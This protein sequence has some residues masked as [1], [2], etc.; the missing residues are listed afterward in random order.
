MRRYIVFVLFFSSSFLF[1]QKVLSLDESIKTAL[2]KSYAIKSAE[3]SLISSRKNLES[4]KSGLMTSV[5]MEFDIPRYSRSLKSQFNPET[6]SEQFFQIGST[7]LESRLFFTQPIP[8]TNGSFSLVGSIFG[9]EQ[10]SES[11]GTFRDYYSNLSLRFR[12]PIFAFNSL[13]ASLERAGINL[14]RAE[15]NYNRAAQDIIYSVKQ[16][17]FQLFKAKKNVEIVEEKVNQTSLSYDKALNK[18][19]AG[20]IAEVE[21]LQL[22][23]DMTAS[24]NELLN[25]QVQL[26]EAKDNFKLLIGLPLDEEVDVEAEIAFLQVDIDVKFAIEQALEN[27]SE[28]LN[29]GA[30]IKL[31]EMTVNEVD[32]K[33]NITALLTANYGINKND[34]KFEDIFY[35]FADDRSVNLTLSLPIWDWGKNSKEVES[36]QANLKQAEL[37]LLNEKEEIKR[38][39]I[40]AVNKISSAK[41]RVE[42]LS[43]S[44]ELAQ[45][46]YEISYSRFQSGTITSFDLSQMQL[47][48]TDARTNSLNALIDYKLAMAELI[49]L[50]YYDFEK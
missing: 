29:A 42:V 49:R 50:T 34:D 15:R 13:R 11:I 5:N 9:R 22:E 41:A 14:E 10:F 33:G 17:F 8:F 2:E 38:E 30:D 3:L 6:Q 36:A 32:S 47:R 43:K 24:R 31:S 40:A 45:K 1:S 25:A 4:I 39:I 7:V 19:K 28:I 37:G 21:A 23:L 44:V 12:Q 35:K 18:F 20:L 48:L 46:S 16:R 26:A 27:R